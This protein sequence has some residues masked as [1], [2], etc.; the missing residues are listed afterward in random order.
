MLPCH[1][2]KK[3][4]LFRSVEVGAAI[5]PKACSASRSVSVNRRT[6]FNLVLTRLGFA[7]TVYVLL[8][9]GTSII[10]RGR[11]IV[12]RLAEGILLF[13]PQLPKGPGNKRF[14]CCD[15]YKNR[16]T[17]ENQ[18]VKKVD[19]LWATE[20]QKSSP[21]RCHSKPSHGQ[22]SRPRRSKRFPKYVEYRASFCSSRPAARF[23]ASAVPGVGD[24]AKRKK[25]VVLSCLE[26]LIGQREALFGGPLVFRKNAKQV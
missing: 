17:W 14:T 23:L 6:L 22:R 1:L 8:E 20:N 7:K 3:S 18:K 2:F 4:H 21:G 19:S 10:R 5:W 11:F 13:N 15:L 9:P 26:A 25:L 16:P 12:C 24:G